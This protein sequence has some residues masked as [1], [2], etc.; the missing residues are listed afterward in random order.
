MGSPEHTQPTLPAMQNLR[1][2]SFRSLRTIMA[3]ILREMESTYGR[4]PGGYLWAIVQ[5]IGMIVLLSAAFSLLVR[6]P[7][8]GTS[9]IF[10]YAT[11][12]LPFDTYGVIAGKITVAMKYSRPL[13][14]YPRVT[15]IDTVIARFLLNAITQT[16]VFC[17]ILG[18]IAMMFETRASL[19]IVPVIEAMI[20]AMIIGFGIGV[21][22]CVLTGLYPVWGLIWNILT[23]PLFIASGVLFLYEEMPRFTQEILWWNPLMHVTGLM[24]RGLYPTYDAS[25]VSL[26]YCYGFGLVLSAV[27]LILLRANYKTVL[28]Q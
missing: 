7:P 20:A 9:F 14:F 26:P 1:P 13:L 3:L 24:R 23:R 6:N 22:N 21:M 28:Q 5:P 15:W 25:Y 10:F 2:P 12:Y 18:G 8:L 11:G 17:I 19:Q 27:G 16:V 4:E